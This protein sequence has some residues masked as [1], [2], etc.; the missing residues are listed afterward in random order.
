MSIL[1][2]RPTIPRPNPRPNPRL[3]PRM[4]RLALV[5]GLVVLGVR[6]G[7]ASVAFMAP[8]GVILGWS[9]LP[10]VRCVLCGV[11]TVPPNQ[12]NPLTPESY[13]AMLT[14]HLS[15]DDKLGQ[16]MMVQISGQD[17]SPDAIQMINAQGAGGILFFAPNIQSGDQIRSLTAQLQKIAPVPLLLSIDQEG[18]VVNRFSSLVGPRPSAASLNSPEQ[19]RQQGQQDAALLHRYGFNLNL[20]PV[21]D[22]GT[23]NP[24]LWS[25]TFGSS[26]DRVIAMAGAYLDGLQQSGQVTGVLKHYPGLGETATDPHVGM[27]VLNSSRADWESID[28]APYRALLKSNDVR[29]ILVSHEMIPAVDPNLPS[30]LSPAIVEDTLRHKMGYNGVVITDSLYMGA[31]NQRW[32]VSQAIVLAIVAGADVVIGPYNAQMVQDA[33]YA[34]KQAITDGTLTQAQIDTSV[35]RI[36]ALKIRM[37]LIPLPK[38]TSPTAS[39]K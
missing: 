23:I 17:L 22:V 20:A 5:V 28:L 21:V 11:P 39:P 2:R 18:G 6:A 15:L 1:P 34:L 35:Q 37:G 24:E 12:A 38:Q 4:M 31:L 26:P 29:A 3:S 27:P 36:L 33:K 10:T 7:L 19:A 9:N 30:S 32:S 13:A 14:Q 25:R 16:L 8:G